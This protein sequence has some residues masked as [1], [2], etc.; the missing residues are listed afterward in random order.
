MDLQ[1]ILD[2]I[3]SAAKHQIKQI[4]EDAKFQV[5][6][7]NLKAREETGEQEKRIL[8]DGRARLNRE[9]ALIEQQAVVRSLQI[10]AD[11]RQMLIEEVLQKVKHKTGSFRDRKD[12]PLILGRLV[13]ETLKALH[14]SSL[15]GQP[16]IIHFDEK[17]KSAAAELLDKVEFPLVSKFDIQCSGGCVAETEDQLVTVKNTIESRFER[18]SAAL[19]QRLSIFFEGKN[20]SV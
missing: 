12:Y 18:A 2:G 4:E 11:A 19:Q 17:D 13:D 10:H 16:M 3:E 9:Q 7:I 8:S 1:A 5:S 15:D 20:T 14:P 6:Q